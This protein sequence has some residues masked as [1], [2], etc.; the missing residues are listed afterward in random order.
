VTISLPH[1]D[2]LVL[3]AEECKTAQEE[4]G[5]TIVLAALRTPTLDSVQALLILT[6]LQYGE[7][8]CHE[9]SILLA[10]SRRIGERISIAEAATDPSRNVHAATS[11]SALRRLPQF[12]NTIVGQEHK[13]RSH[14]M[15]EM[16]DSISTI[17]GPYNGHLAKTPGNPPLPCSDSRAFP[18]PLLSESTLRPYHYCSA[19]SLC[20][21][22]ATTELSRVHSFHLNTAKMSVFEERDAWQSEAQRIGEMNLSPPYIG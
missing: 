19:L 6:V 13:T 12:V 21:L 7:G 14:W 1:S 20:V 11:P 22:L 16:L 10:M 5:S 15:I 2:L 9:A 17:G 8:N 18:E 3:S 4:L